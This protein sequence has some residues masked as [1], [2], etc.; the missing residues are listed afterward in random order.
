MA[1][2]VGNTNCAAGGGRNLTHKT[3]DA[4]RAL[5]EAQIFPK[6][7]DPV[8]RVPVLEASIRDVIQSVTHYG[9]EGVVAKRRD[10]VYEPGQRSGAWRKMRVNQGQEFVIGGYTPSARSFDALIFGYYDTDKLIYV[11]KTRNGFTPHLRLDLYKRLRKLEVKEC[12][13]A[14]RYR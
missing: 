14:R 6:L 5:L 8:R 12:P 11:A 3:L 2:S 1:R 4:R 13:F 7:S 10:S 9:F